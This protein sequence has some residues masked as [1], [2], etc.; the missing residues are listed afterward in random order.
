[1]SSAPQS[2]I[3]ASYAE[4]AVSDLSSLWHGLKGLA[5]C[6]EYRDVCLFAGTRLV[7]SLAPKSEEPRLTQLAVAK[8]L[9]LF[10]PAPVAALPQFSFQNLR[11]ATTGGSRWQTL[12]SR[13]ERQAPVV[14]VSG[15]SDAMRREVL[16][17]LRSKLSTERLPKKPRV[18]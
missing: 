16:P 8:A 5:A 2:E 18:G 10:E 11:R 14:V 12:Q 7:A 4:A 9:P 15:A 1:M 6:R 3:A 17:H 13:L